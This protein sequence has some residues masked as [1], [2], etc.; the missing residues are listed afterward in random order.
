MSGEKPKIAE[1]ANNVEKPK[2]AKRATLSEKPMVVE[3]AKKSEKPKTD[4]RAIRLEKPTAIKRAKRRPKMNVERENLRTQVRGVYDLQKLR[5]Q[6]G[7]RIVANMKNRDLGIEPGQSEEEVDSKTKKYL[8]ILK[9][10][11]RKV[12]DGLKILPPPT[13]FKQTGLISNYTELV[14]IDGY[15]DLER[16]EEKQFRLLGN[17]LLSFPIYS[18]FLLG[19]KGIGPAMAGVIISEIDISKARY[20]SSLW[21]YCGLDTVLNEETEKWEGRSRKKASLVTVTY[22]NREG[23]ESERKSIT[24]NPFLKTKMVG[25]LGSSF[26]KVGAK[27]PYASIYYGYKHRLENRPDCKDL[28]KGHIHNRATRYMIKQFL[29][30]LYSKWRAIDGLEV[31]PPYS[32]GKLGLNHKA[33]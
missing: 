18:G 20:A 1:R 13:K 23:E 19:V 10:D 30:D 2:E 16:S 21:K 9:K 29:V 28:T 14:L 31:N 7:N 15:L 3:R 24:F 27:S 22:T 26:L 33:G 6:M 17:T 25:V 32:K 8:D 4:E 11:Y 12:M 5:I